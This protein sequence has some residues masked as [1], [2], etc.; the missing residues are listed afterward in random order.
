MTTDVAQDSTTPES[1]FVGPRPFSRENS[2]FFFGR[3]REARELLNVLIA[4][5]V[6]LMYSP[7]GAGKTSLLHARLIP[8]LGEAGYYTAP[9]IRVSLVPQASAGSAGNRY[10]DSLLASIGEMEEGAASLLR[11]RTPAAA[12]GGPESLARQIR[13]LL[14]P[15][16]EAWALKR[17]TERQEDGGARPARD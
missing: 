15:R 1:P 6:V 16:A 10:V 17:A 11:Q 2:R 9:M 8:D 14:W 13:R 5:R 7:S 12:D 4:Q 3:E